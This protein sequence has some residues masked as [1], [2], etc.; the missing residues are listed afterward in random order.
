MS[1]DQDSN[2]TF[3]GKMEKTEQKTKR[4]LLGKLFQIKWIKPL[5]L[6]QFARHEHPQFGKM[7]RRF[8]KYSVHDELEQAKIGDHVEF[9]E[10]APSFKNKIYVSCSDN[11]FSRSIMLGNS[12]MIQKESYL[13][14]A[15]NSGAKELMC[16]HIIGSTRKRYAYLGDKLNVQ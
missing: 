3:K 12:A 11:Y 10:G 15:D 8:K 1:S 6:K 13:N 2:G 5:L 16:I 9:Y 7:L 4:T 14:V